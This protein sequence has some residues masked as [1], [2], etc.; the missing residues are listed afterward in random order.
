[1]NWLKRLVSKKETTEE[2]DPQQ[3]NAYDRI[4]GEKTI[5]A[6]AHQFYLQMQSKQASKELL[7]IHRAPMIP[8]A[9]SI[10]SFSGNSKC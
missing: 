7:N 10:C 5:R 9:F 8:I 2:R 1:M 3:S 6:V 4:G